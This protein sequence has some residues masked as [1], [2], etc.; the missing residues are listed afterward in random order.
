[1]TQVNLTLSQQLGGDRHYFYWLPPTYD[2]SEPSP[3]IFSFHGG[4]SSAAEQARIDYLTNP[5]ASFNT[6]S[7][8]PSSSASPSYVV[9]YPEATFEQGT[10]DRLWQVAPEMTAQGIDDIGYV[11]A[12]LKDLR[13]A[14]C[15]DVS[16][17]YSTGMSQGGGMTNLLACNATTSNLFA[18]YAPVSGSYYYP[19]P[20][21]GTC[22]PNKDKLPCSPGRGNIP[23]LAFHGG[24]DPVIA[25]EGGDRRG[26]CTPDIAYWAEQWALRNGLDVETMQ[27]FTFANATSGFQAN[28]AEDLGGSAKRYSYGGG[29][30]SSDS[31]NS[32]T[33]DGL[34]QL[35]FDGKN[36]GH[37]WPATFVEIDEDDG[38]AAGTGPT[39]F[40]AT[41]LIVNFFGRH[42]LP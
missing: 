35:V 9:V 12:V 26:A 24:D 18:A 1:M 41:S 15:L 13:A 16:R 33:M 32:Y 38:E 28:V 7:S 8:S 2:K 22:R 5:S 39:R 40:N 27:T 19:Y 25:Y 37:T 6:A 10:R 29:G 23:V 21:G 30:G 14:L 17:V 34:V 3:V 42:T 4:K 36:V 11:L 31:S 20:A